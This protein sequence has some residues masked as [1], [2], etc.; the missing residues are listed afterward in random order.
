[1]TG[2]VGL[3]L[4]H[5]VILGSD[6]LGADMSQAWPN[7]FLSRIALPTA[8]KCAHQQYPERGRQKAESIGSKPAER[9]GTA[10][11]T[12]KDGVFGTGFL[13]TKVTRRGQK[14]L[15]VWLKTA[16]QF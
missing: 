13:Q 10:N 14:L 11:C 2:V 6:G 4:L 1:V 9:D 12:P 8:L 16:L 15:P 5:G 3:R 7:T